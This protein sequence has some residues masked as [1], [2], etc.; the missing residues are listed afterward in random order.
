MIFHWIFDIFKN[1]VK[2]IQI[3]IDYHVAISK[4]IFISIN[5]WFIRIV[6]NYIVINIHNI[7][8]DILIENNSKFFLF[9]SKCHQWLIFYKIFINIFYI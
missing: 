6:I 3:E 4:S 8:I 5:Q 9:I 1:I 7:D 2:I